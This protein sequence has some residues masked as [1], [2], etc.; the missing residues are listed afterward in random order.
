MDHALKI[1]ILFSTSG[2][3]ASMGRDAR[4]GA[5]FAL[6]EIAAASGQSIEPVFF[7]PHA[8]HL[9]CF[10]TLGT[11]VSQGSGSEPGSNSRSWPQSQQ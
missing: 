6:G 4:D 9:R 8:E 5:E 3:Y 7:D 2:P 1:G 10:P 11:L